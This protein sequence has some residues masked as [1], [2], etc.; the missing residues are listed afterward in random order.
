[1]KQIVILILFPLFVNSQYNTKE[2]NTLLDSSFNNGPGC[3]A[4]ASLDGKTIYKYSTG[5][6]NIELHVPIELSHKFRIGSITKQFTAVSV[7]LLQERGQLNLNDS[8]QK[9]LPNFPTK[10]HKITIENLL[11][12]TSGIKSY[13]DGNIMNEEFM[14]IN[15]HQ[16]S[17]TKTF[18]EFPLEFKPGSQFKY[19]N[20]GYHLL[21]LIIEK[22]S[23]IP[24]EDF[25]QKE[26]FTKS[27]MLNTTTDK[28]HKIIH[29]RVS[30]Y[31][32]DS[33]LINSHFID[34]NIP[35]SAGNI[36]STVGDLKLWY[37]SLFNY[38]ILK[39][40]TLEKA[41]KPYELSNGKTTSYGFGW[42]IDYEKGYKVIHH[43]GSIPG[44]LSNIIYYPK[45]NL[46]TVVLSNCTC[47]STIKP[48]KQIAQAL[49]QEYLV[50]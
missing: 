39:K 31:D 41:I 3:A 9:H 50:K 43:S 32:F 11:T 10:K 27:K 1:M 33:V 22:L 45:L 17:L 21:G 25:L 23:G 44:F 6:A 49:F 30:G 35:F 40:E 42:E 12:H 38:E 18:S 7:L 5:K 14:R 4:L 26:I 19:S 28:N 13:T 16:D 34:M 37:E 15:F 20:S 47:N 2:F 24:Y 29:N 48:S 8:I 36:I 46:L